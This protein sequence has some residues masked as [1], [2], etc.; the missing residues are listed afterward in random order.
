MAK[1]KEAWN[2]GFLAVSPKSLFIGF[3]NY[4]AKRDEPSMGIKV[5]EHKE[6]GFNPCILTS[7]LLPTYRAIAGYFSGCLHQFCTNHARRIIARIIRDLPLKAK[8]DKF[9]YNYIERIKKKG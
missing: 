2:F 4:V 3:F 1:T 5:L 8:K 9:F 6:R 7:D